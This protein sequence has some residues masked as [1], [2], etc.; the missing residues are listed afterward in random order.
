[1]KNKVLVV[2]DDISIGEKNFSETNNIDSI[3][4]VKLLTTIKDAKNTLDTNFLD[5][6]LPDGNGIQLLRWLKEKQIE[7]KVLIFSIN[8]ELKRLCLQSGAHDFFDKS[9][10]F[11]ALLD[12]ISDC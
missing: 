8:K 10:D 7:T 6:N 1:M 11:D 3:S 5:L 4:E 12:T 9:K 2:E